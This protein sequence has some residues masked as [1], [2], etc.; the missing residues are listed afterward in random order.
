MSLFQNSNSNT[1]RGQQQS[2]NTPYPDNASSQNTPWQ[3]TQGSPY[4]DSADMQNTPW[5]DNTNSH[6]DS[7]PSSAGPQNS[8]GQNWMN[9]P[10]LAGID[11]A[12]LQMLSS[13]ATQAQGKSQNELLPFLMAAASQKNTGGMSFRPDEIETIINVMK[14]GKSPQEIRQIDRICTLMRQFGTLH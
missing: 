11:P 6:G 3:D 12:R 14:I 2:K 4:G 1:W 13:L 7:H 9:N 5:Q 8:S 10:A